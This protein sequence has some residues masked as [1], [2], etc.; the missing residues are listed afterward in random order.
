MSYIKL[1]RLLEKECVRRYTAI[2]KYKLP[3]NKKGKTSLQRDATVKYLIQ[4]HK[5]GIIDSDTYFKKCT[6]VIRDYNLE[7]LD[8][9]GNSVPE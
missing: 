2:T 7:Y 5:D 4:Q 3:Y 9:Y 6:A 8:R 1:A